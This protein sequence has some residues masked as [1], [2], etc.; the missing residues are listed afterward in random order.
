MTGMT[1]I[2]AIKDA[3]HTELKNDKNV[4]VFGEDVGLNGGVFRAT[5]GLQGEF[6]EDR[7]FDTP[8]AESAIGVLSIGLALEGFRPVPEIQFSGFCYEV[9]DSM[10]G[11][12][13]RMRYRS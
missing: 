6:G 12:M 1:M 3:I 5:E 2:Q 11:Q 8:L 7:V 13:A 9:M 10:N 4:L